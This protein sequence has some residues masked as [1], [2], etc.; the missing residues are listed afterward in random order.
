MRL[1]CSSFHI[2]N[3]QSFHLHW[4]MDNL[5]RFACRFKDC[6][7]TTSNFNR[8]LNHCWDKHSLDPGFAYKCVC[9]VA[10]ANLQTLKLNETS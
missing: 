8:L 3:V 7:C 5:A 6:N 1:L 4:G 10:Q 9:L 2:F